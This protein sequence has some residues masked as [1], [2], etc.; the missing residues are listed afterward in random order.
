M[1]CNESQE[2]QT[3]VY[4]YNKNS[5]DKKRKQLYKEKEECNKMTLELLI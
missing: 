3:L 1:H 4:I 2:I 5:F